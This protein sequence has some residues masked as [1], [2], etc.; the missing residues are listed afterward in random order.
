MA[1]PRCPVDGGALPFFHLTAFF[2]SAGRF[3]TIN[4]KQ[5]IRKSKKSGPETW[6]RTIIFCF[7]RRNY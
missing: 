3:K 2:S 6:K 4:F 7:F 1:E 5:V